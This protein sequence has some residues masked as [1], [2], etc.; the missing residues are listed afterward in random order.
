MES[1]NEFL[2]KMLRSSD[3]KRRWSFE[4]QAR[5]IARMLIE[6]ATVNGVA[7]RYGLMLPPNRSATSRTG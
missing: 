1:T 4:L 3:G 2:A 7:K 6:G 5:I